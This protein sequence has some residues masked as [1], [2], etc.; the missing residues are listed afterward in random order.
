MRG[1]FCERC[2]TRLKSF[3]ANTI[4]NE[5]EGDRIIIDWNLYLY[6]VIFISEVFNLSS[7][8]HSSTC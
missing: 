1:G 8:E 3:L 5:F 2:E 7:S 6:L 4:E